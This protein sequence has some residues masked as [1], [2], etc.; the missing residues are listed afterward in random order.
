MEGHYNKVKS[1]ALVLKGEK[2]KKKKKK[3]DRSS[4]REEGRDRSEKKMKKN[5][6]MEDMKMNGG[7]W[8]AE[9]YHHI[10]GPVALQFSNGAYMKALDNG[11]FVL[12]APHG[13]GEGPDP[14]E[15]LMAMKSGDS[16]ISLKSG[17]DKYLSVDKGARLVGI[18]D[19][20]GN[21]EMFEP[22]FQDGKMALLGPNGR[23]MT[24]NDEDFIVFNKDRVSDT[25]IIKLRSNRERED[26]KKAEIPEEMRG[27]LS[28]VETKFVKKFQKF[29]DHKLRINQSG[30]H[31]L[32]DARRDGKLHETLLDRREKM[33]SDRMCK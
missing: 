6:F 19:A 14:E 16:K 23:F 10:V 21:N 9:N 7:W 33:K 17:Y 1:G 28:Q 18:S 24:A 27:T 30:V 11:K 13:Q 32:I 12:G 20:V 15:M 4:E 8:L 25:E 3:R 29:Q 5:P 26:M 22:V 31:E 2:K